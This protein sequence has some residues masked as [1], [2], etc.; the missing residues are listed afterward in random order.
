M[1]LLE[2]KLKSSLVVI[3]RIIK[4][5]PKSQYV[6]I[7]NNLFISH[8]GMYPHYKL[9]K[10]FAIQKR[11]KRISFDHDEY[12]KT[13]ARSKTFQE[14]ISPYD[15]CLEHTKPLFKDHKLLTIHCLYY[16]H[17]FIEMFKILKFREPHGLFENVLICSNNRNNL[18]VLYPRIKNNKLPATEQNFLF[19]SC[20]IWNTFAK[21]IF[22]KNEININRGYII[23]GEEANSDLSTGP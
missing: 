4:Y 11:C 16:K 2:N 8:L 9:E 12:N 7:Y 13:C 20:K 18:M 10:L 21:E 1:T 17:T 19:K 22:E 23:S 14:H 15:F 5:I 6:N 3:K